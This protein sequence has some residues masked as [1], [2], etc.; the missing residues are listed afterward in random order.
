LI[1]IKLNG[2]FFIA[3]LMFYISDSIIAQN[4]FGSTP[5]YA[6]EVFI[7][8]TYAAGH[9]CLMLGTS[10][11]AIKKENELSDTYTA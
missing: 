1:D 3:G 7:M 8:L 6:A 10:K 5:V 4:V 2:F 9:S 11:L